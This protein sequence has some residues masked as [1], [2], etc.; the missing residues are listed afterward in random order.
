MGSRPKESAK[1]NYVNELDLACIVSI[2]VCL[3][4]VWLI[5][6]LAGQPVPALGL[7]MVLSY[8]SFLFLLPRQLSSVLG[9]KDTWLLNGGTVVI[10]L[11]ILTIGVIPLGTP[12]LLFQYGFSL[13]G[14]VLLL[15]NVLRIRHA[16][17]LTGF[18]VT[19]FA[20]VLLFVAYFSPGIYGFLT[21]KSTVLG[22]VYTD[23]LFHM[24]IS[25]MYKTVGYSTTGLNTPVYFN[26]HYFSHALLA[27][28]SNITGLSMANTY[29]LTYPL[30]FI[31]LFFRS[32]YSLLVTFCR[33]KKFECV[34]PV[35]YLLGWLI[36]YTVFNVRSLENLHP[37]LSESLNISLVLSYI[38]LNSILLFLGQNSKNY[39]ALFLV[40]AV[41]LLGIIFCKISTGAVLLAALSTFV[42]LKF[43]RPGLI[44]FMIILAAIIAWFTWAYVFPIA[45]TTMKVPLAQLPFNFLTGS[46]GLMM[47]VSGPIMVFILSGLRSQQV[48]DGRGTW[49]YMKMKDHLFVLLCSGWGLLFAAYVVHNEADVFYFA[50]VQFFITFPYGFQLLQEKAKSFMPLALPKNKLVVILFIILALANTDRLFMTY[51]Y[52]RDTRKADVRGNMVLMER[53]VEELTVLD[54]SDQKEYKCIFIPHD[55]DWFYNS[56]EKQ[57]NAFFI[58][59]A[60]SGISSVGGIHPDVLNTDYNYYSIY[61]Y[62]SVSKTIQ[63]SLEDAKS[64]AKSNGYKEMI[65]FSS[66][67]NELQTQVIPL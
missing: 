1:Y 29:G 15:V 36:L 44:L 48:E 54:E 18:L 52:Y 31:P 41:F 5:R 34:S 51:K 59:A 35:L 63:S 2:M 43:R 56:Q 40:S 11:F 10:I 16:L 60:Y 62:R 23:R 47:Y 6:Y 64:F 12:G 42:V 45:R 22:T 28:I 3:V 38:L 61:Y 50:I 65:Y 37:F 32:S 66:R 7:T 46:F 21:A 27:G 19:V 14:L 4:L 13:V 30:V 57:V 20:L 8:A 26:Y 39:L 58:P 33:W 25:N 53:L 55:Q 24:S 9:Y 17:F 67:N 49:Y